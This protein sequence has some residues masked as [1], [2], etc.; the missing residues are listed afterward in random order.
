MSSLQQYLQQ[1]TRAAHQHL[2]QHA[3]LRPLLH[4]ALSRQSYGDALAALH[5]L[6]AESE[7]V[8][9]ASQALMANGFDYR[10]R[11]R[12]PSLQQD[13]QA[14]QRQPWALRQALQTPGDTAEWIGYLYTL[15]GSA[16]GG[17]F[18]A[19]KVRETLGET[20]PLRFFH[21]R[22]R[23][24]EALWQDFLH[25]AEATCPPAQ[26]PAAARGADRVFRLFAAHLDQLT[27]QHTQNNSM[28][29]A[30]GATG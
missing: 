12:L 2:D 23:Q 15:E 24:T 16:L 4:K 11:R 7:R 28:S 9:L 29:S 6:Y 14:L 21:G 1:A 27:G 18:I 13:L 26:Y 5:G 30:L 8:I 17:Q 19:R 22:G 10:P 25:Y 3:L 20:I